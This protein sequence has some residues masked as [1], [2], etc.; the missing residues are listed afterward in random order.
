MYQWHNTNCRYSFTPVVMRVSLLCA[1]LAAFTCECFA[2][3]SKTGRLY[4]YVITDQ[5]R[6]QTYRDPNVF[7]QPLRIRLVADRDDVV[8]KP[9]DIK[10]FHPAGQIDVK[11]LLRFLG[12]RYN[13]SLTR[14]VQP[15][16][17][18][19]SRSAFASIFTDPLPEFND[20]VP[21]PVSPNP[22]F[23]DRAT[24]QPIPGVIENLKQWFRDNGLGTAGCNQRTMFMWSKLP[25]FY[26]PDFFL[27]GFCTNDTCGVPEEAGHSCTPDTVNVVLVGALRWDCCFNLVDGWYLRECGWRDVEIPIVRGCRCSC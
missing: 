7:E 16:S 20:S 19:V 6:C 26:F 25:A 15:A 4:P 22:E 21:L 1:L 9:E 23:Y 24:G 14:P 3:T 12:D 5:L 17:V 27:S 11:L 2:R 8:W 13:E 18:F 10:V